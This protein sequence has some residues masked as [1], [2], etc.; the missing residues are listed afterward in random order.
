L[1]RVIDI[2]RLKLEQINEDNCYLLS[3]LEE[4]LIENLYGS[5]LQQKKKNILEKSQEV[6]L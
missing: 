6:F 4:G 2:N 3:E 5:L 1:Q